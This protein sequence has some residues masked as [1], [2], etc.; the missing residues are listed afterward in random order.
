MTKK[1][2]L[3]VLSLPLI[4]MI[5]L[6]TTTNT[7]SLAIDIPVSG[8]EIISDNI[9]Y[10][11][12]DKKE[13][14]KVDYTIYP[15]NAT[16]QNVSLSTENVGDELKAEFTFDQNTKTITPTSIGMAKVYLNTADGGYKDS[17]I[18]VVDSKEIQGLK[19][20]AEKNAIYVGEQTYITNLFIPA[21]ASN[22]LITYTSS[23]S[24]V[25]TV[26]KNG[27]ITGIGKGNAEITVTSVA[28]PAVQNKVSIKVLNKDVMDL[29]H[30]ELKTASKNGT[31]NIS[32]DTIEKYEIETK[33]TDKLGNPVGEDV[34]K[35]T[36]GE[37][38]NNNVTMS[39]EFNENYFGEVNVEVKFVA[40]N[41]L[42]VTKNCSIKKIED[43]EAT[44]LGGEVL[45][46]AQGLT[47]YI[48]YTITPSD[49]NVSFKA[50]SSNDNI[51]VDVDDEGILFMETKKAGISTI[52]LEITSKDDVN[53]K[54]TISVDIVVKPS[55][56]MIS[57]KA[58][59]YG[60]E[61]VLAIGGI[62]AEELKL[63]ISF[64]DA[65]KIGA[66][67]IENLSW[68]SSNPAVTV[69]DG[70]VEIV[71]TTFTGNVDVSMVFK[72]KGFEQE[73]PKFT[74]YCVGNGINVYCYED[75]LNATKTNNP[76]VVRK[77]ITDF[78]FKKDGTPMP[79]EE[80]YE[81]M[82]TT[83]DDDYYENIG[84]KDKAK[85]KKLISFKNNVYGNGYVVNA[86]NI[87]H[88]LDATGALKE[89]ALF[90]GPLNFVAVSESGASAVSVK[91]Q[92]NIVFAV[93]EGVKINNLKL[94]GC[95]LSAAEG[96]YDLVDLNYTGTVVEVLGD[97][98]EFN[99]CRIMNGRTG[100]RIFGDEQDPNKVI[101]VNINNSIISGA[102]EFLIRM[103][104]NAFVK[105]DSNN[106]SPYLDSNTSIKFPNYLQYKGY[107]KEQKES[108]D[109]TYI[110]TFV[111]VKNCA[112]KDCG[113]F[114]IG[115]D[116][117]FAGHLLAYG[118]QLSASIPAL[119]DLTSLFEPWHDLAKTS[120][121][122]KLTFEGE[123]RIYDWKDIEKVDSSTLIEISLKN[124]QFDSTF[125]KLDFNISEL[126]KY[127]VTKEEFKNVM[128][129]AE[130]GT[131]YV[132]GGVTFFGGGKNYSCFVDNTN[133]I[134]AELMGYQIGFDEVQKDELKLAAGEYPF[135]FLLC[136]STTKNFLPNKQKEILSSGDAYNFVFKK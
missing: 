107:S 29:S 81:E 54:K 55:I 42:V 71:D 128:Y 84:A 122:A 109:N 73:T 117:H 37:P 32:L 70:K 45:S 50:T 111:N 53:L 103:G 102:R 95:D 12:Y 10:L 6:F 39:Y 91:G 98:V 36:L 15:T 16:N 101:H 8:I 88:Q 104:S 94:K 1:I 28:N 77:D 82:H 25:A 96:S 87:T 134:F 56:F 7:V 135:Y 133:G 76:I 9:V 4:I 21:N 120:Y 52:T 61:N 27:F 80:L 69:V 119:R 43:F 30:S 17:F 38:I 126:V 62:N 110:K 5:C 100:M 44:F 115:M 35:I 58:N 31:V 136:D 64:G 19:S 118:N 49:A 11:D 89:D 13:T 3:L 65:E 20:I 99:F 112:F 40:E 79:K 116:S 26:D 127:L 86:H 47:T 46:Y 74:I 51:L 24:S 124:G 68:K 132:H 93:Y 105:G 60:D 41:G 66:G 123:V 125:K 48:P 129:I 67:F 78:G 34:V 57:E 59:T 108:Y 63:N 2:L 90:R 33:V 22:Q 97:N 106:P 130:D 18:V 114:S 23:D 75:L 72:H 14:L 83:Y 121:G 113:I 85:I 131:N 92:D